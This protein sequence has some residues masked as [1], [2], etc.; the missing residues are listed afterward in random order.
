MARNREYKPLLF[1]T[2]VRNPER[3]KRLLW[4]LKQFDGEELTDDLATKVVGELIRYGLYR[5]KKKTD[6]IKEKWQGTEQG[7]FGNTLLSDREVAWM[8][9]H[10]PQNH[11]EAGFAHGYA[12]RFATIFDFT[13]ELGFVYFKVGEP[14]EF[15]TIGTRY[16]S[17]IEVDVRRDNMLAITESHPE[18]ETE[19]FLQAMSRSQRKNPFVKVLNDNIPLV[20]LLR[21]IK[22]LNADPRNNNTGMSRRE[23]P[24]LIFWKDNNAQALYERIMKLREEYGYT[25]SDEVICDLC[26]EEIMEGAFKKFK[27]KSIMQ[28]YPDKFIR[29]MRLT[30]LITLRGAGRFIDINHNEDK[31]V[32]YILSRYLTYQTYTNERDYFDYMATVDSMLLSLSTVSPTTTQSQHL[33]NNWVGIYGWD[34]IKS[35]LQVLAS[36]Q[37]SSDDVLRLIPKPSR[38]EFLTAMAIKY[39][40]PDVVVTPNYPTDDEGLPT[41]TAGGN[42]GDIECKEEHNGIL[43]EVTMASGRTQTIMEIWPIE[44]HL[45]KYQMRYPEAQCIFVAPSI[46]SDSRRQIEYV[47]HTKGHEIRPYKIADFITYLEQSNTLYQ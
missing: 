24:L 18:Y 9:E 39:N 27:P 37:N 25:P 7:A 35:E 4:L 43:V 5:P 22:L 28:E 17:I 19:A 29:K 46:F 8:L 21:V 13:K 23:L 15:S 40:F 10:N 36:G 47:H 12:S 30:G 2:T 45:E 31:K 20:L 11:K 6:S 33:L 14:I 3:I 44:R 42:S 34:N 1:T 41:S 26:T 38:L 32:D 16:A